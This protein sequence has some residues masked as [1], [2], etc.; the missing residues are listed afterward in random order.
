MFQVEGAASDIERVLN[1]RLNLYRHPAE[2]RNFMAPDREPTLALDVPV[3]SISGLDTFE[4]PVARLVGSPDAVPSGTGS[5]PG[6]NC[7]GSDLRVAY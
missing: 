1:I 3:L 6:G 7:I 4:L 5:G 2:N